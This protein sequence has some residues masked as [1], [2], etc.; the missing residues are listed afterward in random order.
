M[1][2]GSLQKINYKKVILKTI[3]VVSRFADNLPRN[4]FAG[5][6]SNKLSML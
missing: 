4:Q 5:S 2:L 3:T 6:N 1:K